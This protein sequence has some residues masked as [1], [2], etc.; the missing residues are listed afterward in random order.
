MLGK[1]VTRCSAE[2]LSVTP[3]VKNQIDTGTPSAPNQACA[4]SP[5]YLYNAA[6]N[7]TCYVSGGASP[8]SYTYVKE[9]PRR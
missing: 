9:E 1:V 2:N 6:G 3:D 8:Q 4:S 5:D 7:M